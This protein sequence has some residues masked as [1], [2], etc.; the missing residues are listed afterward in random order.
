MKKFVV[1]LAEKIATLNSYD[2]SASDYAKNTE[3][4]HPE[5]DAQK[6]IYSLPP[7][8]KIID[9]GCGPGRDAKTFSDYGLDVVGVDFSTNMVEIAKQSVPNGSFYTIDM[10]AIAFPS[11]TF[12]GV[13]ANCA[14]LHVPKKNIPLFFRS[15]AILLSKDILSSYSICE[16]NSGVYQWA[17]GSFSSKG[18]RVLVHSTAI[19]GNERSRMIG[20]V[21]LKRL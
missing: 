15:K 20:V 7:H 16:E 18:L 5:E 3:N 14:L 2:A 6:F 4:F 9:I 10:E 19:T 21:A 1:K 17:I 12:D 11:E 13:W 8:A